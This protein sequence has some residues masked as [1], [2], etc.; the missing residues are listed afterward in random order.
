MLFRIF[1]IFFFILTSFAFSQSSG[2]GIGIIIGE[3]TGISLKNWTSQNTALDAG[4]AW[5]FGRKGA[6]HIHADYLIHE[7][8]MIET[9]HGQ[10]PVYYGI[11]GRV[12]LASDFRVGVRGVIGLSYLLEEIPLDVFLEIVPIFDLVPRTDLSFNAGIGLRYF[13]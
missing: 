10:L 3:P 5:A 9:K 11:G 4:V 6:L 12:L 7:F 2:F 1:L 13:L 8:E